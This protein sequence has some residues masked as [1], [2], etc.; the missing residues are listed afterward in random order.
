TSADV[1]DLRF[2]NDSLWLASNLRGTNLGLWRVAA[3]NEHRVMRCSDCPK[4]HGLEDCNV[5]PDGRLL[6]VA[7]VDG[8]H[9]WNLATRAPLGVVP[10]GPAISV[11]FSPAA[12]E[13]LTA[14]AA[15]L[16]RWQIPAPT[17]GGALKFGTGETIQPA[18][19]QHLQWSSDGGLLAGAV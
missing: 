9:L 13:L 6:A 15:G 17:E 7:A 12:G 11:A 16:R 4:A 14:G 5:S 10:S 8:T 19:M 3:G 1:R 2:S 18:R